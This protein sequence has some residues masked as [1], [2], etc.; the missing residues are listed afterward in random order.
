MEHLNYPIIGRREMV[1]FPALDL[2]AIE[3]KIDTGAY[4]TSIHCSSIQVKDDQVTCIF[5]DPTHPNYT[6]DSHTFDIVKEVKVRS[7]N[8]MEEERIVIDTKIDLMGSQ[9]EIRLTL[10]DRSNMNFPIL[11]GRRF[12]RKK[13]LVDVSR[14]YLSSDL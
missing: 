5:L 10:T 7:S 11:L 1:K 6:G 13:F 12:L 9:F 3:A 2:G 4:T 14:K 8:G